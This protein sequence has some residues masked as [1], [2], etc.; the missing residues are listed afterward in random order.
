M[1]I[2]ERS[3]LLSYL[4]RHKPEKANLTLD[5]EGWCDVDQ[6]LANTDFTEI[7]LKD[8]VASDTK[9]RYSFS[10]GGLLVRANQGH[11]T[12]KVQLTF[13]PSTGGHPTAM[14]KPA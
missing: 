8:I 4:L 11:S 7:E 1:T 10:P 6:L 14:F 13:K 12:D 9:G 3:K 2:E 5:R